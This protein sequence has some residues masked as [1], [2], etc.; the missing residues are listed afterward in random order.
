MFLGFNLFSAV[1]GVVFYLGF[2]VY[3]LQRS[4]PARPEDEKY[5]DIEAVGTLSP[6]PTA[7]VGSLKTYPVRANELQPKRKRRKRK[8]PP[9]RASSTSSWAAS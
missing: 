7:A 3:S 8:S 6:S 2:L 9:P 1:F 4:E 5:E